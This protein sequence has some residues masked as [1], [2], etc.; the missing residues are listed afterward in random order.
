MLEQLSSHP[1]YKTRGATSFSSYRINEKTLRATDN[2]NLQ[3]GC[4]SFVKTLNFGKN[5]G[6]RLAIITPY[7]GIPFSMEEIEK[8]VE[9]LIKIGFDIKYH[10]ETTL[11]DLCKSNSVL[12]QSVANVNYSSKQNNYLESYIL[13]DELKTRNEKE[14][15]EQKFLLFSLGDNYKDNTS[16]IRY[17]ALCYLRLLFCSYTVWFPKMFLTYYNYFKKIKIKPSLD[18]ILLFTYSSPILNLYNENTIH[19]INKTFLSGTD[20]TELLFRYGYYTFNGT[21]S[22]NSSKA[23]SFTTLLAM[24]N[25]FK[26]IPYLEKDRIERLRKS[27]DFNE[28]NSYP[29]IGVSTFIE[30]YGRTKT[31]YDDGA[32][33]KIVNELILKGEYHKAYIYLKNKVVKFVD[34]QGDI[35]V[36]PFEEKISLKEYN[37]LI[38][39]K[40]QTRLES[41]NMTSK[42]LKKLLED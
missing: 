16:N 34:M 28:V 38:T 3:K 7:E 42:E 24:P 15:L 25:D 23:S 26:L 2:P 27:V 11:E 31:L 1:N 30:D 37:D 41:I 40:S 32:L 9:L 20:I 4:H 12:R 13:K 17:V 36:K 14:T 10:G 21:R 8:Y 29:Y 19:K 5:S 35:I 18:K 22:I 33:Q 6:I 39:H